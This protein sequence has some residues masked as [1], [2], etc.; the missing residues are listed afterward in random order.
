MAAQLEASTRP[1]SYILSALRGKVS[2]PKKV[3][4]HKPAFEGQEITVRTVEEG[5]G[6][7]GLEDRE[8]NKEWSGIFNHI[9]TTA[10]VATF[11]AERL[12]EK[13]EA[14][15]PTLVLNTI[16]VSHC[17]RRQ[18]DEA[19]WYPD[20]VE[21]ASE[22]AGSNDQPL[23]QKI[24]QE[25]GFEQTI[26][27]TIEAHGVGT[28]YPIE[29]MDTWE[30]KLCM[31]ADFRVGQQIMSLEERFSDMERGIASGRVTQEQFDAIRQW[32]DATGDEI[33]SR[34]DI[35]P[36][37]ITNQN[38]PIPHWERHVRRLYIQDAEQGIFARISELNE[39]LARGEVTKEDIKREFPPNT[40]WGKYTLDRYAT[41]NG[42][43][44]QP[45]EGKQMGIVRA[46]EFYNELDIRR[47]ER[48]AS[49]ELLE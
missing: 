13:G 17:G 42:K 19:H 38:P 21:N 28:T 37:M 5:A 1:R 9:V 49:Q 23:A 47:Q 16:L 22:K 25:A 31:Y 8:D 30:K 36:D 33:F 32:A 11:L 43:S 39:K 7:V 4:S 14:V 35:T 2:E 24:L 26:M 44:Y 12:K 3:I 34:L 48:I 27:D 6:M 20:V 41:Q 10:R 15:D 18:W 40:W 46:I 45:R 29:A